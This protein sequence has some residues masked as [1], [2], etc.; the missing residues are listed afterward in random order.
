M[1]NVVTRP[2]LLL[3]SAVMVSAQNRPPR[4]DDFPAPTDWKGP[5]AALKLTTGSERL[6]RTRLL[7]AAKAPPNFATHY[8]FTMWGCGSECASGAIVDLGTGRVIA[9]P[10]GTSGNGW[11]RFNV[12]WSAI[13]GS[14]VEVRLDSRLMIVRCGLRDNEQVER[15][16]LDVYYFVLERQRFRKLA[17]IHE[18]RLLSK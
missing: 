1:K 14:G 15:N 8:R 12:C 18:A 5:A 10:L 7:K 2:A 6:F 9:S 17:H 13:E 16:V 4:F 11:M 3:L